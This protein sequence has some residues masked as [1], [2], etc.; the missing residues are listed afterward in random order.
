MLEKK[1]VLAR[2]KIKRNILEKEVVLTREKL[3][4]FA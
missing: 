3:K 2:E 1:V 4:E